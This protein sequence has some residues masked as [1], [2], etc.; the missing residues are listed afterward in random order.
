MLGSTTSAIEPPA[1]PLRREPPWRSFVRRAP[2]LDRRVSSLPSPPA[3]AICTTAI[4]H[5]A[6]VRGGRLPSYGLTEP[7]YDLTA[8]PSTVRRRRRL[9]AGDGPQG[10]TRRS[11]VDPG[12][13]HQADLR[14]EASAAPASAFAAL[15][16]HGLALAECSI[17]STITRRRSQGWP[18]V[19]SQSGSR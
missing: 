17:V 3:T 6:P 2:D 9:V 16:Q 15:K 19:G 8:S 14:T 4:D 7:I 1:R 12:T 18:D 11:H 10:L 5:S 13:V